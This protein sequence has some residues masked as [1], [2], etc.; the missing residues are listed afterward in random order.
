MADSAPFEPSQEP[1]GTQPTD[2]RRGLKATD[3]HQRA[4][5]SEVKNP[6]QRGKDAQQE[7]AKPVDAPG[8]V[9]SQISAISGHQPQLG[10]VLVE[11][12]KSAQIPPHPGL[13]RDDR[14]VLSVSLALAAI[15]G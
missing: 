12:L 11:H 8:P 4:V 5:T 10:N 14:G 15:S 9:G 13:I 2:C 3:Q 1:R 7:I 6:F